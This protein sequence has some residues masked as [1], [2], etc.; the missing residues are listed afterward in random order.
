MTVLDS[1]SDIIRAMALVGDDEAKEKLRTQATEAGLAV[2]KRKFNIKV[3]VIGV[4]TGMPGGP[5]GL[6]LEIPDIAYLLAAC[7]R[8]C[9]GIGYITRGHVDYDKD[10]A[11]ILAIWAGAAEATAA[12]VAGKVTL[13]VAGKATVVVGAQVGAKLMG[14]V[15]PKVAG[16]LAAKVASKISTKWIPLIGGVVSGGINWWVAE[17]IMTAAEKYYSNDYVVLNEDIW[18]AAADAYD[19]HEPLFEVD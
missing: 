5:G 2:W 6:A 12:I 10:M 14:K 3:G 13:K 4:L 15:I 1:L 8:G 9:Y 19:T 11:L 7:G 18:E 17:G 16:K